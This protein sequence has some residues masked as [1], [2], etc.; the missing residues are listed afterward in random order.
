MKQRVKSRLKKRQRRETRSAFPIA[1]FCVLLILILCPLLRAP[2]Y[3]GTAHEE[4][5]KI[6]KE[7]K[8]QKQK[9]EEIRKHE[10][11]VLTDIEDTNKQL[12]DVETDLRKYRNRL[13]DTESS[14]SKLEADIRE[15]KKNIERHREWLNRKL[16]A[17]HKYGNNAD[18]VFLLMSA[19]DISQL[20]RQGKYLQFVSVYEHRL[21]ETYK[22]S[23]ES[24]SRKESQL[25]G[26]KKDL[27]K[28]QEKVKNQEDKLSRDI[29]A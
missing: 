24:L 2:S 16:R 4:Y 28:N 13:S 15:N 14:I 1:F 26:L 8:K 22:G 6:Q 5:R 9:I 27:E 10:S 18:T 3:A 19:D 17:I 29:A 23:L 20:M 21:L 7:I 11:S 12:K 25:V